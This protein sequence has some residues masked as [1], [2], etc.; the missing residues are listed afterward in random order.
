ML[1]LAYRGQGRLSVEETPALTPGPD[2]ARV[3]VH[4]VGLCT[5][6]VYGVSGVNDR[7]DVVLGPGDTLVMGHE[8]AGH[9]AGAPAGTGAGVQPGAPVV[10]NPIRGCGAC[11]D[12]AVGAA[13]VCARR[14][15]YGCLPALPGAYAD[16]LV[17]P[18]ANLHPFAG[19]AP[20]EWGALVEP[21]AVGAHGVRLAGVARGDEL[22]VVGGGMIGLGAALS[23]ARRGAEPLVLE[24]RPERRALAARLGLRAA[25]P[26]AVLGSGARFAAAVDCVARPE[27]LA[28]AVAAVGRRGTV[29]LVGIWADEIPLPVSAVVAAETRIVGSYAFTDAEFADVA[30]WVASGV[31]DLGPLIEHRTGWDDLVDA[32]SG[33]AD[34]SLT[35]V[36]TLFRPGGPTP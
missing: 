18:A 7:R 32:F 13:N 19:P 24:P 12:C 17:V 16:E 20:L 26:S 29:V 10:V 8:A 30:G 35:A 9:V 2:E 14:R 1:A 33:Y 36:R 23:A 27:T 6:D 4:A 25:A 3:R 34:G 21:I 22:L 5:S 31:V 11:A 15:V 28:G